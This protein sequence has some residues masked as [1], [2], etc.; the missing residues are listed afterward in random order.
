MDFEGFEV[1]KGTCNIDNVLKQLMSKIKVLEDSRNEDKHNIELMKVALKEMR[2]SILCL[3]AVPNL[4]GIR[5]V[6]SC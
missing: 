4:C 1:E 3:H 2:E 5:N 6:L